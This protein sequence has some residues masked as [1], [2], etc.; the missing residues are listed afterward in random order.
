MNVVLVY[1]TPDCSEQNFSRMYST[2]SEISPDMVLGD[3]NL[4]LKLDKNVDFI[5]NSFNLQNIIKKVTR[6]S[7]EAGS[8]GS[9]IDHVYVKYCKLNKFKYK[10]EDVD[11]SVSDHRL[12]R[13]E[14]DT[15]CPPVKLS[16]PKIPNPIR[17]Y[18]PPRMDWSKFPCSFDL[19]SMKDQSIDKFYEIL[20]NHILID[21]QYMGITHKKR[22]PEQ[23]LFRFNLSKQ[24]RNSISLKSQAKYRQKCTTNHLKDLNIQLSNDSSLKFS[25][26]FMFKLR[27]KE[28]ELIVDKRLYASARNRSKIG[29]AHV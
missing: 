23:Q 3:I 6:F 11:R 29:R 15:K 12:I 28:A 21:C 25:D 19:D 13:I 22:L 4:D 2:L 7:D 1:R 20:V 9:I 14:Y 16:I 17:R 27:T 26:A 5:Y 8:K 18:P 10:I 24:A